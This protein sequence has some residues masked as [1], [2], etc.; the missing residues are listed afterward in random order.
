MNCSEDLIEPYLDGE[1]DA[2]QNAAL[3][4]HIKECPN[5][6]KAYARLSQQK[7]SIKVAAPYYSAPPQ[8]QRSIRN[9]LRRLEPAAAERVRELRWRWA[10][11]AASVLFAASLSWNVIQMR[12]RTVQTELA[13]I[14][15]TD[16]IRSLIGTHLLDVPSSDQHTVKPWF[17]G[18]LDFSPDV[19]DLTAQGFPLIGGRVEYLTG[20]RVAAL[21]YQ[22]RQHVI[23]LFVWPSESSAGPEG[24]ISR[25]GYNLMHWTTGPMT[26]WA[27]SD[28]NA[29]ELATLR[30]L[31]K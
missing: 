20:R 3:L 10:A 22:R 6:S 24:A 21:V 19:R 28:L 15:L 9:Q 27:V 26:Y 13:D 14:V 2:A 12:P 25:N 1:L 16:H 4:Q 7:A 29:A 30:N 11:I 31:Y 5:C 18:K 23:N 8:L 17:A